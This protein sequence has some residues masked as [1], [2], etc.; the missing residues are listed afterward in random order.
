M[1]STGR[2]IFLAVCAV[3][4]LVAALLAPLDEWVV[5]LMVIGAALC[6]IAATVESY[7]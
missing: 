7:R 6:A 2:S 3:V 1:R 4:T 5:I